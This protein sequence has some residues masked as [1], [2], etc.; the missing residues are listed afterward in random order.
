MKVLYINYIYQKGHINFD[1]IHIDALIKQ[2]GE[3]HLILH[4]DIAAQLPYPKE[5]YAMVLPACFNI[6]STNGIINRLLYLLTLIWIRV[7]ISFR[8]YDRIIL[9]SVEEISLGI[10]PLCKNMFIICHDNAR[11]IGKGMKGFFLQRLSRNNTFVVFNKEMGSPF[12]KRNMKYQC[13]SH[14]C[15]QPFHSQEALDIP[16]VKTSYRFIIF[17]PSNRPNRQF[18][19]ELKSSASFLDFLQRKNI[20]MILRSQRPQSNP[21][22]NCIFINQ[23]L[24]REQYQS[25]FLMADII[26]LA[27]PDDFENRVSGVSFECVANNKRLLLKDNPSL[28]YCKQFYN[29][30]PTFDSIKQLTERISQ[31]L[32]NPNARCIVKPS[33]LCPDYTTILSKNH[34]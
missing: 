24:T 17:H 32:E 26:L 7:N 27:Y 25:L 9:S 10:M 1:H 20:L 12:A 13:V 31:L 29:Y 6:D 30:D 5:Q 33:D 14:G 18:I 23:Y 34:V 16:L 21:S 11:N 8:Q 28:V 4:K 19:D 15:I 3:V 2:A 22:D